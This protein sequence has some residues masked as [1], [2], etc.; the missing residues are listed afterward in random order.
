MPIELI[1]ALIEIKRA[2]AIVNS[3]NK[4][5]DKSIAS[6]IIQACDHVNTISIL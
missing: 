5:L 1:R 3:K 6:A 2:A 4:K